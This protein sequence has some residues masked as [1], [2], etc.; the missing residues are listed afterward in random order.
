MNSLVANMLPSPS[1]NRI[2]HCVR[3][4]LAYRRQILYQFMVKD[5]EKI[6]R[7]LDSPEE[8]EEQLSL[9]IKQAGNEARNHRKKVLDEHFDKLNKIIKQAVSRIQVKMPT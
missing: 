8:G 1:L 9:L 4:R 3:S 5:M 7:N 2:A 6:K